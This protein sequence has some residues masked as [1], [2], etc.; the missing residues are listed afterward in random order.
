MKNNNLWSHHTNNIIVCISFK[1][2]ALNV[3]NILQHGDNALQPDQNET[4]YYPNAVNVCI[5]CTT[6]STM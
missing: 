5:C 6:Y 2:V 1:N 4:L 3:L